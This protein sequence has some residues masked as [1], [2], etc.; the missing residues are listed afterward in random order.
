MT[1]GGASSRSCAFLLSCTYHLKRVSQRCLN[2]FVYG[3]GDL[4]HLERFGGNERSVPAVT[5]PSD[6]FILVLTTL[7]AGTVST[8]EIY[9]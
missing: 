6:P 3:E 4:E 5:D 1:G 2:H 7:S 9:R 8:K